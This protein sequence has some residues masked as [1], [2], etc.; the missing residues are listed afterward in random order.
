MPKVLRSSETTTLICREGDCGGII[1]G[2]GYAGR[3]VLSE[4]EWEVIERTSGSR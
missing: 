3:C 4:M 1:R 2:E